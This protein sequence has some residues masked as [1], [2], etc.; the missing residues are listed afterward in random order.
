MDHNFTINKQA[1]QIL[2]EA[3]TRLQDLANQYAKEVIYPFCDKYD[4]V[5]LQCL[6]WDFFF[7]GHD[8]TGKYPYALN[9]NLVNWIKTKQDPGDGGLKEYLKY[10]S[11]ISQLSNNFVEEL[12]SILKVTDISP[13]VDLPQCLGRYIPT[14]PVD[15]HF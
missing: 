5:F 4:L 1:E 7:N 10:E 11:S 15:L 9:L 2:K 3:K 13:W 6:G 14:Y 12:E 8:K